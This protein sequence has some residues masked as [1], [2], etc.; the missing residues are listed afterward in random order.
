LSRGFSTKRRSASHTRGIATGEWRKGQGHS[1][2][3]DLGRE[4]E[5]G[6]SHFDLLRAFASDAVLDQ[7]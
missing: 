6:E 3:F 1:R 5:P 7:T 4:H 2:C